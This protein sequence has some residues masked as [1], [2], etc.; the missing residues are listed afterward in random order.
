MII[1]PE[2]GTRNVNKY[3]YESEARRIAALNEIFGEVEL[4]AAEMRTLIWLAGWDE[5]TIENILSAIRKA[6]AA[7]VKRMEQPPVCRTE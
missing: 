2:W 3:F 4:T 1:Q 7:E 6:M 5:Y